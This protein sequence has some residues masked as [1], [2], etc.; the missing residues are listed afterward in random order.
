MAK[1]NGRRGYN[2]NTPPNWETPDGGS[3]REIDYVAINAKYSNKERKAQIDIYWE[4][5]MRQNQQRRFQTVQLY[6]NAAKNYPKPLPAGKGARLTYDT[7]R[8][9]AALKI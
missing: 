8:S 3:R 4:S 1:E 2:I 9:A 5:N 7:R 6:Y